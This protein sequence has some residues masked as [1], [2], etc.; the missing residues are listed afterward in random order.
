MD[1]KDSLTNLGNDRL[2]KLFDKKYITQELDEKL[3]SL[4]ELRKVKGIGLVVSDDFFK[5]CPPTDQ[6]EQVKDKKEKVLKYADCQKY[7]DTLRLFISS[8][9]KLPDND[10]SKITFVRMFALGK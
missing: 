1:P 9:Y 8:Y 4:E 5:T 10:E 3:P 7:G 6:W 2:K